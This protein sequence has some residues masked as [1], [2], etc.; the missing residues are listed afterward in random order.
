MGGIGM[1][2]CLLW[3]K[4]LLVLDEHDQRGRECVYIIPAGKGLGCDAEI[5]LGCDADR[6]SRM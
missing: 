5:G 2:P 1:N 3:S 6:F 4:V